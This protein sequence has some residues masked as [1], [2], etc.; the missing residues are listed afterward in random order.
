M[1]HGTER[2][3]MLFNMS[4]E[5]M[6]LLGIIAGI[7]WLLVATIKRRREEASRQTQSE[8]N[9]KLLEQQ[10][11][12]IKRRMQAI[13]ENDRRYEKK[14][15]WLKANK[16]RIYMKTIDNFT[17]VLTEGS[18]HMAREFTREMQME[19]KWPQ[20]NLLYPSRE[21]VVFATFPAMEDLRVRTG[22]NHVAEYKIA[23]PPSV[24]HRLIE[25]YGIEVREASDIFV[26]WV[27]ES[28]L[29]FK[30][31]ETLI[32]DGRN[33]YFDEI[34]VSQVPPDLQEMPVPTV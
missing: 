9:T 3:V 32:K 24:L 12:L 21:T 17:A 33:V 18:Y 8:A 19:G 6:A 30:T 7:V 25:K 5:T 4:P 29:D 28:I 10:D 11:D 14:R 26:P 23:G 13:A 2:L 16:I 1:S 34:V 20:G 31:Q 22:C 27:N 15:K